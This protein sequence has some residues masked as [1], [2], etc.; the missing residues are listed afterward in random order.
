VVADVPILV[1]GD[2][3]LSTGIF[4]LCGSCHAVASG[5]FE[6]LYEGFGQYIT[7][8]GVKWRKWRKWRKN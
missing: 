2:C 4:D 3:T 5:F 8:N 1:E 7:K 6:D